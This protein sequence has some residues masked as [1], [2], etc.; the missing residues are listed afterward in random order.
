MSAPPK[1]ALRRAAQVGLLCLAIFAFLGAGD[2]N[3]RF[4]DLGHRL[5]CVC[6][7]N[8]IL[9]E[10]NH[11]GCPLSDGMRNELTTALQRGDSDS[12]ILQAFV[13]KYGPTI[14]A[15]PTG[16]GFDRV[17]WITPFAVLLLGLLAAV[18][19]IRSWRGEPVTAGA[20][21]SEKNELVNRVRRETDL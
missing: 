13:Q 2:E 14:L 4:S 19:I 12:L 1:L 17:A 10:C 7:C 21:S 20:T 8:Q 9:L 15:A 11:V 16:T 18:A 3:T 5:M 6:G